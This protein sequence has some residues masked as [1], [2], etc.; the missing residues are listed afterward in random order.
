[1]TDRTTP[2]KPRSISEDELDRWLAA[3]FAADEVAAWR[4]ALGDTY[5]P[6]AMPQRAKE[7]RAAGYG[8]EGTWWWLKV[9]VPVRPVTPEWAKFCDAHGWESKDV[10][11]MDLFLSRVDPNSPVADKRAWITS[12]VKPYEALDFIYAGVPLDEAQDL[13]EGRVGSV[14]GLQDMLRDRAASLPA[15]EPD[16]GVLINDLVDYQYGQME[17]SQLHLDHVRDERDI[18]AERAAQERAQ[19]LFGPPSADGV[20]LVGVVEFS[21]DSNEDGW[22]YADM[23]ANSAIR[24][25]A[26]RLGWQESAVEVNRRAS[27]IVGTLPNGIRLSAMQ[28]TVEGTRPWFRERREPDEDERRGWTNRILG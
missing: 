27:P 14:F 9:G 20:Y 17:F 7:W 18:A 3:G 12:E 11:F 26:K 24:S 21:A 25:A 28:M 23:M 10:A 16:I 6:I 8:A 1:M 5:A 4:D 15:F 13:L 19:Q 2:E 22:T